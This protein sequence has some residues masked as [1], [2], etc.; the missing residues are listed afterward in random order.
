MFVR[1]QGISLIFEIMP[2]LT[3]SGRLSLLFLTSAPGQNF[4]VSVFDRWRPPTCSSPGAVGYPSIR[5][6]LSARATET[7]QKLRSVWILCLSLP[8]VIPNI[9]PHIRQIHE[10][11]K[12]GPSCHR[13][14]SSWPRHP[15]SGS[16]HPLPNTA[17]R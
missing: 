8:E 2:Q 9:S 4:G 12:L 15:C 3:F 1:G 7:T 5:S 17:K 11:I 14:R 13:H 16:C 10:L 6:P